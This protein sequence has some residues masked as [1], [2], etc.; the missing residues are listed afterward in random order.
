MPRP[1]QHTVAFSLRHPKGS[2]AETDFLTAAQALATIPGV[3]KFEQLEQVSS[4]SDF[5]FSFSMYFTD[6][7]SYQAY[8]THPTHVEFVRERWDAEVSSFQELDFTRLTPAV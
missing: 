2:A 8:N 1:I 6:E 3:L 5:D 4:Q 7:D